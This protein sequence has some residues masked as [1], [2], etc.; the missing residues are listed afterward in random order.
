[1]VY[2]LTDSNIK[3]GELNLDLNQFDVPKRVVIVNSR[4]NYQYSEVNGEKV[5]TDTPSKISCSVLDAD[6]VKVLSEMGISLDDLKTFTLEITDNLDKLLPHVE[7]DTKDLTIEMISPHLRLSW[8]MARSN[9]TGVKL[10]CEDIK[11]IGV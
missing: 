3:I 11:I 6:K 5:K 1:M 7:T 9:W 2:N 8:N 4:V 10:V